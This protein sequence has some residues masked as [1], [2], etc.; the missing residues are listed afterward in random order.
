MG[1]FD[2][3]GGNKKTSTTSES[4]EKIDLTKI[5]QESQV[6]TQTKDQSQTE[7][8]RQTKKRA[9]EIAGSTTGEKATGEKTTG[10]KTTGVTSALDPET[11][12]ILQNLI[13]QI[14]GGGVATG[15][16][17]SL[18]A[19]AEPLDFARLLA[20]RALGTSESISKETAA[21]VDEALRFGEIGIVLRR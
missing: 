2:V 9:E 17:S 6:Q 13:A 18:Q 1:I 3:L 10:E 8:Q 16:P 15:L 20:T 14:G 19:V 4:L 12:S 7:K 21:I 11:L 5:L